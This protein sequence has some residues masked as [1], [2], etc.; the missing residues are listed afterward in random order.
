M[1]PVLWVLFHD[2]LQIA[3]PPL[4]I[5]SRSNGDC[6]IA[7]II[8]VIPLTRSIRNLFVLFTAKKR[9]ALM[10]GTWISA[11]LV[12]NSNMAATTTANSHSCRSSKFH[13]LWSPAY[14]TAQSLIDLI[15]RRTFLACFFI[16]IFRPNVALSVRIT[17]LVYLCN[18]SI[19]RRSFVVIIDA[20]LDRM[21]PLTSAGLMGGF[22]DAAASSDARASSRTDHSIIDGVASC[23][24]SSLS[25]RP[26]EM[27][28]SNGS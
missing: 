21:V 23:H 26:I 18:F 10:A 22:R 28:P 5:K 20:P 17:F 11:T 3:V 15:I 13:T 6:L 16:L 25:C 27:L 8:A 14:A 12:G 24:S 4:E 19:S 2:K 9:S 1:T 7:S